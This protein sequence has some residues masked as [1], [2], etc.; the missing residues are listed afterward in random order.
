MSRWPLSLGVALRKS[1]RDPSPP[2]MMEPASAITSGGG[3]GDFV[4]G[5]SQ[6]APGNT[7]RLDLPA[8]VGKHL[9]CVGATGAGKSA[10]AISFIAW[11]QRHVSVLVV[12]AK[13]DLCA[14]AAD[15]L[16]HNL[17]SFPDQEEALSRIRVVDPFSSS[18]LV[19]WNLCARDETVPVELQAHELG[20]LMLQSVQADTG[21]RQG[22]LLHSLLALVI[23]TGGTLLDA[24]HALV[25][26]PTLSAF[27]GRT[28]DERLR[29]YFRVEFPKEPKVTVSGVIAR[30]DALL[31][32]PSWRL[33]FGSEAGLDFQNLF[34]PG[35]TLV[36]I[37][38]APLGCR[39]LQSFAGRLLFLRIARAIMNRPV[40]DPDLLPVVIV[41]DEVQEFLSSEVASE[42]ERLLALARSRKTSLCLFHQQAAQ[43]DKLSAVLTKII[44]TNSSFKLQFRSSL[45]DARAFGHALPVTGRVLRPDYRPDQTSAARNPYLTPSEERQ[46]L[47]ERIPRLPSRQ[48]YFWNAE[49]KHARLLRSA[50][51]PLDLWRRS[52]ERYPELRERVLAGSL[53]PARP[54][55]S[56]ALAEF[57]SERNPVTDREEE[58]F[59]PAEEVRDAFPASLPDNLEELG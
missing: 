15:M 10:W 41:I 36:N 43:L 5:E 54:R 38:G 6:G 2:R 46:M 27:V 59:V 12:D 58:R 52:A 34:A 57:S 16:T 32:L 7:L 45:E 1:R 14:L 4:V 48:F 31:R 56:P 33:S 21:I 47:L 30:L 3:T 42:M 18:H 39:D 24:H 17:L 37:G 35:I 55:P 11:L 22:R 28:A 9:H 25:D 53:P 13:G 29:H 20:S 8:I 23:D 50:D 51:V 44:N 26:P 49:G 40:M 19:S